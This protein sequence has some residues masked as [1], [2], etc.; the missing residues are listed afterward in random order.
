MGGPDVPDTCFLVRADSPAAAAALVD[1]ELK[2]LPDERV[3]DFA[4][5][6]YEVGNDGGSQSDARI[7]R[8]P[9]EQHAYR[10]GW[11]QWLR[12]EPAEPW[13]ER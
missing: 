3:C 4:S 6:I 13:Q 12:E 5:A 1:R 2:R 11:R 8:S 7:L 10:H 9:Y